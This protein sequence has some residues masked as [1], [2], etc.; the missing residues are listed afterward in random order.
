VGRNN[1]FRPVKRGV[2]KVVWHKDLSDGRG[3]VQPLVAGIPRF[4]WHS[5]ARV[6]LI[7][8]IVYLVTRSPKREKN[9]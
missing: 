9:K 3:T 1:R 4:V 2:R 5:Q 8:T 7:V 6:V